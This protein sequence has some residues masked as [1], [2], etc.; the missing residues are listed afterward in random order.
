MSTTIGQSLLQEFDMETANTRKILALVPETN[1]DFAPHPKSMTLA[2]LAGHLAEIPLWASMTLGRDELDLRPNGV[3]ASSAH[4]FT[5]R[6]G[7]LA[8]FDEH[9]AQARALLAGVTDEQMMRTW[10]LKNNGEVVLAMPKVAILRS[11]VMNHMIHHRAQ[12]GVYL[13]MNNVAIPGVYGPSAD[14]APM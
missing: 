1:L 13:R 6:A 11:F 3:P 5:S 7:T 2:R 14:E 4:V 9:L 10:S 8:F 12:L